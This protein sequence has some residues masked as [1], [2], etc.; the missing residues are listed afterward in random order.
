MNMIWFL[1]TSESQNTSVMLLTTCSKR[2]TVA[3]SVAAVALCC[4]ASTRKFAVRSSTSSLSRRAK[5]PAL[6]ISQLV[7]TKS[8]ERVDSFHTRM[9]IP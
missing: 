1:G 3:A 8:R 6:A 2:S 4:S 9:G 7:A 5:V